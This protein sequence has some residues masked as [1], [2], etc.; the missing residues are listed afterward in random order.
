[1]TI[2]RVSAA[3]V[4]SAMLLAPP[5]AWSQ[6]AQAAVSVAVTTTPDPAL[7]LAAA[8][9]APASVRLQEGTEV[10][11]RLD[12]ELSSHTASQ[13]DTFSITLA[14]PVRLAD[15]TVIPAGSRGRGEVSSVE[16]R[17]MM[18]KGGQLSVRLDYV[19]VG[20]TKVHL[21]ANQSQD[22]KSTQ[23]NAIV[24]SLLITPL[25]LLM[26]GKDVTIPRG[27]AIKGYVDSTVDLATPFTAPPS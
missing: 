15:G 22:G 10:N 16:K 17:G 27:Q 26:K 23:T 14:D 12:D 2:H 18:G 1:M 5:S 7:P 11:F 8:P 24:L 19:M 13:G 6:P 4:A 20:D 21:R 9:E 25:F 3:L